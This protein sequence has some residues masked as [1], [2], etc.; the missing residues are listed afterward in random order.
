MHHLR[1]IRRLHVWIGV[2]AILLGTLLP[3]HG[4]AASRSSGH[5]IEVCTMQGMQA[6][7]NPDAPDPADAGRHAGDCLYCAL[8]LDSPGL[9]PAP[10]LATV[11]A[12]IGAHALPRLFYQSPHPLFAWITPSPRAPP[13]HV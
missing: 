9:P 4:T 7:P 11:A 6:V 1:S 10:V 3:L 5:W 12:A 8:G 13:V 2:I